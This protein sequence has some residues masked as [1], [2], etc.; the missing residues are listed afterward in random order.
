[1]TTKKTQLYVVWTEE[2]QRSLEIVKS[3]EG[4]LIAV[5]DICDMF[6]CSDDSIQVYELGRKGVM[7]KRTIQFV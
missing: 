2:D 7:P 5:A 6:N 4:I 3:E 1:M